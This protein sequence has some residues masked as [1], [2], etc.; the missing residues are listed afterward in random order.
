MGQWIDGGVAGWVNGRVD[1]RER[2]E[3]ESTGGPEG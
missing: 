1:E 2:D 3:E